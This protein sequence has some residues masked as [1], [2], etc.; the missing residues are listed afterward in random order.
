[1]TATAKLTITCTDFRPLRKNTLCGFA[2]VRIN[3]MRLVIHDL[4][5]HRKGDSRWAQLPAK[6]MLKDG[7]AIFKDGKAQYTTILEFDHRDV[8]QAF[9]DRVIQA[10]LQVD[11]HALD[12]RE[13]VS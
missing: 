5:I 3:E 10:V 1:V 4:A 9:S 2:K 7:A 8:R 6:P 13:D 11:S 12:E